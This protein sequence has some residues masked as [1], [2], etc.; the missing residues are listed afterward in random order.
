MKRVVSVGLG[1][2][3]R[4]KRVQ[5]RLLGEDFEIER[6]GTDGDVRRATELIRE[7]DGRVDYI[8]LGG[9]DRA[10]FAGGRRYELRDAARMAAAARTTPVVDGAGYKAVVEPYVI[11]WV[12][13][14]GVV[15]FEGARVLMVAATDRPAMAEI[16]PRLGARVIYGDLMFAL[17]VPV[18]MRSLR[19]VAIVGALFLP[20]V[21]RLPMSVLYPTG[22][23]QH[24]EKQKFGRYYRWADVL[25]GDFHYI[26]RHLPQDIS[27]KVIITN[28]LRRGDLEVLRER[29]CRAVVATTPQFEGET[30]GTNVIEG[31]LLC[32]MGKRPEEASQQ[33]Y[34]DTLAK[35]GWEPEVIEF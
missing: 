22:S 35:L 34:L 21:A 2:S 4:N 8:G 18:P 26:R 15:K 10:L 14:R 16:L 30:F 25:A 1:A 19:T 28:T 12:A 9:T 7:L 17:G 24:A 13:R 31:V 6:V 11:E 33:D 20:L 32:L 29:R 3:D 23:K 27:G 5:V